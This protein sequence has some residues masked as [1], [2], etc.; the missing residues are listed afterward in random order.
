MNY[1]MFIPIKEHSQRVPNKNFRDFMGIPLWAH[2]V[3]KF[4]DSEIFIDTDSE[5]ILSECERMG[6]KVHAYKRHPDLIGDNV[7]VCDLIAHFIDRFNINDIVCQTHVTSPFVF[8]NTIADAV[9]KMNDFDS[10]VSC[11]EIQARLWRKESYGFCPVNH[12]PT[13]LEQTQ[14]LPKIYMENSCFYIFHSRNFIKNKLR[15]G[16]NPCFYPLTYPEN[17]DIDTES[18]W[19]K[20]MQMI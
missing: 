14:D 4:I 17:V 15:V 16:Q 11:D 8:V 18:D 9:G 12:N 10:V 19:D 5:N 6:G 7:S 13:R 3:W 20:V 2:T 1:K